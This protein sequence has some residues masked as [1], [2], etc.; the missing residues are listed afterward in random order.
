MERYVLHRI[1][2]INGDSFF[3]RGEAQ[4]RCE[5]PWLKRLERTRTCLRSKPKII[6]ENPIQG[7]HGG[8]LELPAY[9]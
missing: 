3:L 2:R 4:G 6:A 8:N 5:G 9:S 1:V 7:E